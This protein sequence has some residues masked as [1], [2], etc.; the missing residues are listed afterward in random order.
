MEVLDGSLLLAAATAAPAAQLSTDARGA[1]PHDVQQL[2]VIDY[3]AMENSPTA[4]DL[5]AR[6]MPPE[7]KVFDEALRKSALATRTISISMLTNWLLRCPP[8]AGSEGC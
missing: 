4:M 2:V 6:V 1:I 8:D 5:R 3:R 7:L